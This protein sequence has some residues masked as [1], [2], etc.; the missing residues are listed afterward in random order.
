MSEAKRR[1]QMNAI[2]AVLEFMKSAQDPT[3][4][5]WHLLG[6]GTVGELE[7]KFESYYGVPHALS[8]SSATFGL[9]HVLK[10]LGLQ[11]GD[12]LI[13]TPLTWG[14]TI[15]GAR[16]L[17]IEIVFVDVDR[18][19]GISPEA[20]RNA[21]E[22]HPGAAALLAV[23]IFGVPSNMRE[24]RRVADEHDLAYVADA[25]QSFGSIDKGRPASSFADVIVTSLGPGKGLTGLEG[26]M[27]MAQCAD[28]YA[29]LVWQSQHPLRQK[30]ELGLRRTN[31]CALNG[32]IHPVAATWANA[33]FED[34]LCAIKS[35]SK[36]CSSLLHAV[37]KTGL[38]TVSDVL[39]DAENELRFPSVV[40]TWGD[41]RYPERLLKALREQG[42]E[43]K[44]VEALGASD[45]LPVQ[46][47][48]MCRAEAKKC[49]PQAVSVTENSF[50]LSV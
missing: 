31:E 10:A 20:V 18:R 47:G 34:A 25:A 27:V 5:R 14:G 29:Q 37:S 2:E 49:F 42:Y 48:R 26:G 9:Y 46:C 19:L 3:V 30:R 38:A 12:T 39:L 36:M 15:A 24:L 13:T 43:V 40:G 4:A 22:V 33:H 16:E 50:C 45:L 21:A 1:S 17:G 44:S 23:D 7:R 41:A 28:L 6:T 32:R 8:F 35:R 11:A